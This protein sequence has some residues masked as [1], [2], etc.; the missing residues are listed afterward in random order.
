MELPGNEIHLY[1]SFPDQISDP[2]LLQRYESLLTDDE[3][4]QMSRLYY[5]RHRHQY[6]I[7]RALIRTTLSA[8]FRL[9]PL[10]GDL[11]KTVMG[12]RRSV[13]RKN[14]GRSASTFHIAMA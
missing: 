5:A 3:L 11:A 2:G 8:I 7:T 9:N 4:T 10:P 1:F 12:N 13:F 14:H 6:L